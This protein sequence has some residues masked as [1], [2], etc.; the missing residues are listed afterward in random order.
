MSQ[1]VAYQ[2]A[3]VFLT[4][5][6]P[7]AVT[8]DIVRWRGQFY[9]RDG[10]CYRPITDEAVEALLT[11]WLARN[12]A[13]R[14]EENGK[15]RPLTKTL[16]R[17]AMLAVRSE[18]ACGDDLQ[19]SS[20]LKAKPA[21]TIGPFLACPTGILD[22]GQLSEA[23]AV[24][25]P[26]DPNFFTLAALAVTP[27]ASAPCPTWHAFL[28]ET[29]PEDKEAVRLLQEIF[30]YCLWPACPYEK[31]FV[32][33]G[34]GNTGKSTFG[35]TLQSLLG[36]G[37][38]SALPLERFGERFAL[39]A[40]IGKLANIVFDA[41]EIDKAAEGTLKA[42]VSGEPVTVEQKH[43]PVG[44]MRLTAKHIF[45]TNVL[46]R[47]RDTSDGL[48]RRLSLVSFERVCPEEKRDPALKAKLRTELPGIAHWTLQGLARLQ[49]EGRFTSSK[50]STKRATEYRRESNP[51]DL[52]I[53]T[54][55]QTA[56]GA[57]VG[58]Q[59]LYARY[60]E[61]AAVHGHAPQSST[62]F[63]HEVRALI[64]QPEKEV[65]DGRGGDRMFVG[66]ALREPHDVVR[67]FRLLAGDR[68][69]GA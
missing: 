67:Q 47:F 25:L 65:R 52:F 11:R 5:K 13:A 49:Q 9:Q 8:P 17:D 32:L 28:A 35:E 57:A 37:N 46:P 31:F 33:Y 3:L 18:T 15:I 53:G 61:W 21:G 26:P 39:A 4:S 19:P 69:E 68:A 58:R 14:T 40:L 42:L 2:A 43:C 41:S 36:E 66:L 27:D 29:F 20:W 6:V 24:L 23:G 63:Y 16:T 59:A 12:V 50:R 34:G 62:R 51:V 56:A 54:E 22:L 30:G 48:W 1:G 7:G 44:T 45:S 55:C 38:V 10:A 60:K 64:P